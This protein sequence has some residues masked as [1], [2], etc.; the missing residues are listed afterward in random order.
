VAGSEAHDGAMTSTSLP[1]TQPVPLSDAPFGDDDPRMTFGKAVAL[2]SAVIAAV[3][4]DQ[5]DGPT[6]C[7]DFVVRDLL[8]HLVT[9]LRRVAAMG[10]G[11][12]PFAVPF[13]TE[14]ADGGHADAWRS[15]AHAVMAA[16][17]DDAT[18]DRVIT[19]PWTMMT[20]AETLE[21]YANEVTLHTWDLAVATGQQP[22]WDHDV[23]RRAALALAD[24]LPPGSDRAE[25]PFVAEVAVPADA[26]PIARLVAYSGRRPDWAA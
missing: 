21:I 22:A 25:V 26:P 17:T 18:L 4:P 14:V 19:L 11:G 1:L 5:L 15:A 3:R 13:V 8:G 16:W 7:D 20:G 10:E 23:V 2:G 9:V 24:K 12:D 6:P